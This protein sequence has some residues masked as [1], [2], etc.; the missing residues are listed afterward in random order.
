[1]RIV[2]ALASD[3][4]EAFAFGG[5]Y[6]VPIVALAR[7][8]SLIEQTAVFGLRALIGPQ[9]GVTRVRLFASFYRFVLHGALVGCGNAG[10][11]V[12]VGNACSE[13]FF[14]FLVTFVALTGLQQNGTGHRSAV[15]IGQ[16]GTI[17]G[18]DDFFA[19]INHRIAVAF[20]NK[21]CGIACFAV[22][23][24]GIVA[25]RNEKDCTGKKQA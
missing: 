23:F 6:A 17:P 7:G 11:A 13:A 2:V 10:A 19:A 16:F 9:I 25:A 4:F 5:A 14:V 1:M 18:F 15:G 24:G 12:R 8:C 22:F 20:G 21:G 3:R